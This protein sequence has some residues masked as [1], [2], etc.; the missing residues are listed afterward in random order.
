MHPGR[1]RRPV[2]TGMQ[3]PQC[4]LGAGDVALVPAIRR[5]PFPKEVL[6]GGQYPTRAEESRIA[7]D[8]LQTGDDAGRVFDHHVG[9]LRVAF[10]STTPAVVPRDGQRRC[11]RPVYARGGYLAGGGRGDGFHQ[12]GIACRT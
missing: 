8:A 11:E 10:V 5:V 4:L 6:P 2:S 1:D 9:V 7:G 3:I 12:V